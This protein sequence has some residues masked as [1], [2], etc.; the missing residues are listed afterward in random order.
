MQD[1][2]T[3]AG[4]RMMLA[5]AL[6]ALAGTPAAAREARRR[7]AAQPFVGGQQDGTGVRRRAPGAGA[8]QTFHGGQQEG[9]GIRRRAPGSAVPAPGGPQP[10]GRG[11]MGGGADGQ[12]I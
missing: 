3:R 1:N 6:T 5:L 10:P 12:G 9:T 2:A 4:R 11:F 7:G 8:A